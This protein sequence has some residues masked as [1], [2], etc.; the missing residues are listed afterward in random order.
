MSVYEGQN[1]QKKTYTALQCAVHIRVVVH[2]ATQFFFLS[3]R[4]PFMAFFHSFLLLYSPH[5]CHNSAALIGTRRYE[6]KL[7]FAQYINQ[8]GRH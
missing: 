6:D 3:Y 2:V 7:L 8:M 4:F 1:E 5:L